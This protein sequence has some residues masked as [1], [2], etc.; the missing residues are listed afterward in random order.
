MRAAILCVAIIALARTVAADPCVG[1][2]TCTLCVAHPLCGWCSE[3][4]VYPNGTTG[5]QCAGFQPGQANQ[6]QCNGIFSTEQ[7]FAGYLCDETD[8]ICKLAAPGQGNTI[9]ICEQNCTNNGQVYLCNHTTLKCHVVPSGTP[10]ASSEAICEAS[11]AHPSP[12][13]APP[14]SSKPSELYAC[15][16]TTGTCD[17]APAGKGEAKSVCEAECKKVN[18]NDTYLC[19][20][21]LKK[22]V[23]LP[24]GT[25]GGKSLA[26]CEM[27]CNPKPTPG[28]PP[29]LNNGFFRGIQ[30]QNGYATG[31]FD[32]VVN[33]TIVTFVQLQGGKVKTTWTGTPG[34]YESSNIEMTITLTSGPDSGKVINT[35]SV[36]GTNTPET[37]QLTMA[38]SAPGGAMPTSIKD[39]MTAGNGVTVYAFSQCNTPVCVFTLPAMARNRM[40]KPRHMH[41]ESIAT[42][43]DCA[44]YSANCSYC[45]SRP[46]CGWCSVDVVY[47][48][49]TQG[50]QCAGF[51]TPNGS[52]PA[53]KCNGRYSTF[54]CSEGYECNHNTNQ[55][56]AA[57]PG[58]GMPLDICK[59][60][61]HATPP[62][63][64]SQ[65]MALCNLTTMQCHPC[66]DNATNCPGSL[67]KDACEAQCSHHKHG[68]P[69]ALIGIWRGIY[70]QNGYK[71]VEV[72]VVF[73]NESATF[74]QA[75]EEPVKCNVT[76]LG[77]DVFIFKI[78]TGQYKTWTFAGMFQ[79]AG[80]PEDLY[81]TMTLAAGKL[82]QSAPTSFDGAMSTE[83]DEVYVLQKCS[84]A[85]CV[86]KNPLPN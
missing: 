50:K 59:Q 43:D 12:H 83:G 76:T 44:P 49:G 14:T 86:F 29:Q 27:E 85:P 71:R 48:D 77:S 41:R 6:F 75:G 30:I 63:T 70:I 21:G 18:P 45:L 73:D 33:T 74:V 7:C 78:M 4:V 31:V 39:A 66:P 24:P 36:F 11:C 35:F 53:W 56:D 34:H 42:P 2:P 15:N 68:P 65:P 47:E 69:S 28:P 17:V 61:C 16:E 1:I 46:F 20:P 26:E 32:L 9:Q 3:D 13:P 8:F 81:E 54:N 82:G 23:K 72:D 84:G 67:P 19:N 58:N 60:F 22:C 57:P 62:P 10:G 38:M 55:C 64:P 51:N 37:K 5:G 40:R 79:E 52:G 25:P 80:Q